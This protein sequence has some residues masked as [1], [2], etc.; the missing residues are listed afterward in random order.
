MDAQPAKIADIINDLKKS[1]EPVPEKP[2]INLQVFQQAVAFQFVANAPKDLVIAKMDEVW[3]EREA[4][5]PAQVIERAKKGFRAQTPVSELRKRIVNIMGGH[6]QFY[7]PAFLKILGEA[8][9]DHDPKPNVD[10]FSWSS[11]DSKENPDGSYHIVGIAYFEPEVVWKDERP[12]NFKVTFPKTT[13]TAVADMVQGHLDALMKHH[14]M[15]EVN[16]DLAITAGFQSL[17]QLKGTVEKQ[18][19]AKLVT[20]REEQTYNYIRDFLFNKVKISPIPESWRLFK[21]QEAY[22]NSLSRFKNEDAFLKAI[23]GKNRQDIIN[24][25][26]QQIAATLAEQLVFKSWAKGVVDGD[27]DLEHL[28]EYSQKVRKHVLKNVIIEEGVGDGGIKV[29][30]TDASQGE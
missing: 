20:D 25:Y 22:N 8:F 10:I 27:A 12:K 23:G 6:D 18:A 5:I 2:K 21:A 29:E 14:K 28:H 16:N 13:D 15:T 1:E 7:E 3:M 24:Y 30:A 19:E 4:S 17:E 9:R 26:S 11:V